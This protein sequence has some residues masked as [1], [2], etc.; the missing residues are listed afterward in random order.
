[1]G[2]TW[3]HKPKTQ[4]VREVLEREF[5]WE[6]DGASNKILD[7]AIVGMNVAY[8]AM[9]VI[10]PGKERRVIAMVVLLGYNRKSDFNFGYKEMTEEAGPGEDDCPRRIFDLLTPL[11]PEDG[12]YAQKW[13]NRVKSKLDRIKPKDGDTITFDTLVSFGTYGAFNSFIFRSQGGKIWFEQPGQSARF[14]ITRWKSHQYTVTPKTS[15]HQ[16]SSK[17][18]ATAQKTQP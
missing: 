13:R 17:P 11:Q 1:M 7:L 3:F 15:C 14:H 18:S 5:N 9:E 2:W 10:R 8:G 16:K 12:E 4:S 6:K